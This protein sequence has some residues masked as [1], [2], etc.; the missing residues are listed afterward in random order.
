MK[1]A[2]VFMS[3]ASLMLLYIVASAFLIS[4]EH[5]ISYARSPRDAAYYVSNGL[6]WGVPLT[7]FLAPSA[8]SAWARASGAILFIVGASLLIW[9]R[10]VNPFFLPVVREPQR[11]VKEGPYRFTRHPG[12]M[13]FIVM[14]EGSWMM[15]GH[16]TGVFPLCAYIAF[17]VAVARRENR[18]I[19]ASKSATLDTDKDASNSTRFILD[20]SDE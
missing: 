7:W 4:Y 9:A 12:Y 13:G 20:L 1:Y 16:W 18:I 15:L 11:V 10:R 5:R 14:A 2:T 8:P 3:W 19:Y 17:L 6:W